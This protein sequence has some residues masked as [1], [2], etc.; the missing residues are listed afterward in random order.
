MNTTEGYERQRNK[1]GTGFNNI[2]TPTN[3]NNNSASSPHN[4]YTFDHS[5]V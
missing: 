3:F 5:E 4:N 1:S 2:N